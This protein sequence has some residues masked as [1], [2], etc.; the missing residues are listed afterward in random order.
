MKTSSKMLFLC[1]MIVSTLIVMNSSSWI[2]MWAGLEINLMSF[3][4]LISTPKNSFSSQS[5]MMYF[6]IQS[7]ASMM[8]ITFIL[9][10]KYMFIYLNS[11]LIKT[12]ILIAMMIKMG[13]PP[14]HLWFPE[15]MNKMKWTMCMLL[16]TWQKIAPMYIMSLII[17]LNKTSIMVICLSAIM[18]AVGGINHTSTRKILA[19]S[20]INHM[21]WMVSCAAMFK[22]SWMIYMMIYSIMMFIT[23]MMM[24]EYNIMFINQMNIF[25][26]KKMDKMIIIFLMMSIGGLPPFLGFIP[27]WIAI[28]YMIST[29]EFIMLTIMVISSLITLSY[30]LRMSSTM[31]MT[32]SHSQKW[33]HLFKTNKKT[34]TYLFSMN[35]MLP[36]SILLMN[37][38]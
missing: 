4:P 15:I 8:F 20:S 26:K 23:S 17:S 19:Y 10:N 29:N 5:V 18:G 21:S 11:D 13:M 28:Q 35:L 12:L 34:S 30:Y 25:M 1:M 31:N 14:F 33:M 16:M 22:K 9:T 3:I 27:K 36:V 6:L 37:F 7:L 2:S 24:Y 38:Y 32:M